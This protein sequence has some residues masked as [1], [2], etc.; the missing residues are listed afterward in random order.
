[1]LIGR[2]DNSEDNTE[3]LER[4]YSIFVPIPRVE[5]SLTLGGRREFG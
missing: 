2:A 4:E 1:M 3:N 5:T